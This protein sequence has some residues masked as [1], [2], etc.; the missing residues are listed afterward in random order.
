MPGPRQRVWAEQR[1]PRSRSPPPSSGCSGSLRAQPSEAPA[2]RLRLQ[3]HPH[4][5]PCVRAAGAA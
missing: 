4:A 2:R 3:Q 1:R 5:R